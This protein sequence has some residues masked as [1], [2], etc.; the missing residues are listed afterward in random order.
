MSDPTAP[1][2]ADA[3]LTG[4]N[5]N[6]TTAPADAGLTDES[7]RA[8]VTKW[9]EKA[10][11]AEAAAKAHQAKLWELQQT[12][13][14]ARADALAEQGQWKALYETEKPQW[15]KRATTA[16]QARVDAVNRLHSAVVDTTL[17]N[18]LAGHSVAPAQV[19]ALV[20]A[21]VTVGDDGAPTID[22]SKLAAIPTLNPLDTTAVRDVPTLVSAYLAANPHHALSAA[23]GGAG[24]RSANGGTNGAAYG[25]LLGSKF[26]DLTPEQ[27]AEKF[28]DPA[29]MAAAMAKYQGIKPT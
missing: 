29:F 20:R 8:E 19:A 3:G 28:A 27:R 14:K 21:A 4:D 12:A 24:T 6:V 23:A 26:D 15:E 10:R 17:A 22:P 13:D 11:T 7:L 2:P 1:A 25:D 18:A 9:R 5:S 16:E